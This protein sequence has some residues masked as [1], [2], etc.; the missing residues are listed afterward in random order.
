M[1]QPETYSTATYT[2]LSL[3][4]HPVVVDNLL[5]TLLPIPVVHT[6]S[7]ETS[8][9]LQ[10]L[11]SIVPVNAEL[12]A[13]VNTLLSTPIHRRCAVAHT[14]SCTVDA[15]QNSK[16]GTQHPLLQAL[17]FRNLLQC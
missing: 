10:V 1:R 17:A 16:C 12:Q 3:L 15:G 2:K 8:D 14:M 13:V 5:N 9:I 6:R 7:S 4:R 11:W